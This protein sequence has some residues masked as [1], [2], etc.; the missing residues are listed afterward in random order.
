MR[1]E[2]PGEYPVDIHRIG[3]E[4]F[5]ASKPAQSGRGVHP[6]TKLGFTMGAISIAIPLAVF[7]LNLPWA[8]VAARLPGVSAG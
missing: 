3:L 1:K 7:W 2:R 8:S 4:R 6:A 5:R